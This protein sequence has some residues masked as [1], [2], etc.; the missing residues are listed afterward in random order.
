MKELSH[1]IRDAQRKLDALKRTLPEEEK[2]LAAITKS[3]EAEIKA[4]EETIRKIM[5][6]VEMITERT[7]A[8]EK[9]LVEE[10]DA[11]NVLVEELAAMRL[12]CTTAT[13]RVRQLEGDI[14]S[15]QK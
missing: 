4:L 1:K 5:V 7:R 12:R 11:G 9:Q 3:A 2:R 14:E 10:L 8:S 15:L 13:T 6:D